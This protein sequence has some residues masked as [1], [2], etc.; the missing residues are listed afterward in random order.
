MQMVKHVIVHFR[1][2]KS[3]K[4]SKLTHK[5]IEKHNPLIRLVPKCLLFAFQIMF[6]NAF[7]PPKNLKCNKLIT[8]PHVIGNMKNRIFGYE[9]TMETLKT[10]KNVLKTQCFNI[11]GC[12]PQLFRTWT[13]RQ[14]DLQLHH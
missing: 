9:K 1:D 13:D 12:C 2:E 10:R 7:S 14:T 11:F 6:F 4:K 5:N 3:R 8:T